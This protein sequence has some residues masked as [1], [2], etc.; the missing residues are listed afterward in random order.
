MS[1]TSSSSMKII[2]VS[3]RKGG[4]GKTTVS[5]NLAATL[6]AL[7]FRV[8][9]IDLDSQGHCA[10]GLGIKVGREQR[11][12]H[13]IFRASPC[14]ISETIISSAYA[15]LSL[16]PADQTFEHGSGSQDDTV[17]AKALNTPEIQH[18]FDVVVIDTPP[19]LDSLLLNALNAA[20][21]V[22]IPFV[23]HPLS[24]E[25]IKQLT[26]VLFKVMSSSNPKLKILG[27]IPV[28]MANHINQHKQTMSNISNDFGGH[29]LLQGIRT[30]I[31]L[32]ESFAAGRPIPYYDVKSRATADFVQLGKTI[33]TL[34]T[35]TAS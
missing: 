26:R 24:F 5:V 21:W 19:S 7:G 30:D 1:E 34:L 25:G 22:L 35:D 18:R 28:M 9:L 23:P 12:S 33:K 8:L 17:L 29:R 2:T 27:F 14:A 6:A 13:D 4:A 20:H 11:K 32:A 31:R 3:N 15:R 10:V 16:S